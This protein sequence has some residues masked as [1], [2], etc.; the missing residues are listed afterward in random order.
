M[1][2]VL[3]VD[4]EKVYLDYLARF[5]T[6]AGH[7]VRTAQ[8]GDQARTLFAEQ[9]P[10]LVIVDWQLQGA[11]DGIA[12]FESLQAQVPDLKGLLI[13]GYPEDE[14]EDL[15]ARVPLA[16]PLEKPFELEVLQGCVSSILARDAGR[17]RH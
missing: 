1:A 9:R 3:L 7:S 4:D 17:D 15:L 12:V 11:E 14:L 6:R 16:G 5:L 13:T 2:R 10:E 8:D